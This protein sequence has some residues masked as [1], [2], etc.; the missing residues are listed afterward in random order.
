MLGL[1]PWRKRE[2]WES[3]K[4]N[5]NSSSFYEDWELYEQ[6]RE[7]ENFKEEFDKCLEEQARE[8]NVYRE[9]KKFKNKHKKKKKKREKLFQLDFNFDGLLDECP[10]GDDENI[11]ETISGENDFIIPKDATLRDIA[12][13]LGEHDVFFRCNHRLFGVDKDNATREIG[14]AEEL[15]GFLFGRF[16]SDRI[17]KIKDPECKTLFMMLL[18]SDEVKKKTGS[19]YKPNAFSFPA[20][21]A[22]Y[23]VI[24]DKWYPCEEWELPSWKSK[25]TM[26]EIVNATGEYFNNFARGFFRREEDKE[27]FL[28][29]VYCCMTNIDPPSVLIVQGTTGS[30]KSV[31]HAILQ[32]ACNG[33]IGTFSNFNQLLNDA[34]LTR[35]DGKSVRLLS[36]D[37]MKSHP[38][39]ELTQGRIKSLIS[40]GKMM[41]GLRYHGRIQLEC[42]PIIAVFTN[43][44]L[45]PPEKTDPA[46]I[47]KTIRI[48]SKGRIARE[49]V[50]GYFEETVLEPEMPLIIG[51]AL[52]AAHKW[53]TGKN[54]FQMPESE[55]IRDWPGKNGVPLTPDKQDEATLRNDVAKESAGAET[56]S[57]AVYKKLLDSS[58]YPD[59]VQFAWECLEP[60]PAGFI[61]T[62]ELQ[63]E[64]TQYMKGEGKTDDTTDSSKTAFGG[65]IT[66]IIRQ[67]YPSADTEAKDRKTRKQ[68]VG[69]IRFKKHD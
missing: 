27:I 37:D 6:Q 46:I 38:L 16:K 42:K 36:C 58:K 43:D 65:I 49:D 35:E 29:F 51:L 55:D 53:A 39:K 1:K 7:I 13:L 34:F 33:R 32:N 68:G 3:D 24:K 66:A 41:V 69:G 12:T 11:E 62:E 2:D 67:L 63:K 4:E 5:D 15:Q 64:F 59:H 52:Q 44:Y 40:S 56:D 57:E 45:F 48:T 60:V 18:N 30:G 14:N 25:Y 61:L 19:G 47:R 20:A 9:E 22:W 54:P 17:D 28:I 31:L 10:C 8:L 23:D 50:R 26:E 21:N